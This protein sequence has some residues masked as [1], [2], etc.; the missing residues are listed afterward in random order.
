MLV[1]WHGLKV[2]STSNSYAN[3]IGETQALPFGLVGTPLL[4]KCIN[5]AAL[6]AVLR[7]EPNQRNEELSELEER[8]SELYLQLLKEKEKAKQC[9]NGLK[10]CKTEINLLQEENTTLGEYVNNIEK[11]NVCQNCADSLGNKS[12]TLGNVCPRQRQRKLKELKTK[13]EMALWFLDSYG[14]APKT[15]LV[16]DSNGVE[17]KLGIS[18]GDKSAK[19]S[20]FEDLANEE[21]LRI[22][23]VLY[24]LDTFCIGDAAYT[25]SCPRSKVK[26]GQK[27]GKKVKV[28]GDGAKIKDFKLSCDVFCPPL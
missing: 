22:K 14:A 24:V 27:G 18:P 2:K 6:I 23:E 13:V 4:E 28:S 9:E 8:C 17:I 15:L 10:N 16:E 12:N 7:A 11:L 26:N 21:K 19:K 1:Y 20:K 25:T 5:D 3:F